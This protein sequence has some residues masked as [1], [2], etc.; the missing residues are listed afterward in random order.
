MTERLE[1]TIAAAARIVFNTPPTASAIAG[2]L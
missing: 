2:A 1:S